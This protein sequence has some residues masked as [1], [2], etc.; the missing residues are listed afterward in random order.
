MIRRLY[1]KDQE[2]I[3]KDQGSGGYTI[4]VRRS[5]AGFFI[6][7]GA[8]L[9]IGRDALSPVC[10]IFFLAY[11]PSKTGLLGVKTHFK[12]MLASRPI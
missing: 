2:V 8:T 9:R 1:N 5:F 11:W 10:R 7:I 12:K 4:K 3:K 6:G